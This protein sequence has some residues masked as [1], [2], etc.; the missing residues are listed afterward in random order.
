V[1]EEAV[2]MLKKSFSH[3]SPSM[4]NLEQLRVLSAEKELRWERNVSEESK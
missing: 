4:V 1:N 3:V 2:E